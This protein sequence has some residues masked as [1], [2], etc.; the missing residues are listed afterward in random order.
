MHNPAY[1]HEKQ[2]TD[3]DKLLSKCELAMALGRS[4]RYIS[5]M[6]QL[7]FEMPGGR[8]TI[9]LAFEFLKA[10]PEPIKEYMLCKQLRDTASEDK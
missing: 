10:H 7:G 2:G 9:R 6:K 1:S 3:W 4:Q 8:S 5:Y